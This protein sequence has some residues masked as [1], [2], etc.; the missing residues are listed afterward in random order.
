MAR[1]IVVLVD[2]GKRGVKLAA[3]DQRDHNKTTPV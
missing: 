2:L 1:Y 3:K